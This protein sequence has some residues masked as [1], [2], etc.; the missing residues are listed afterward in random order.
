MSVIVGMMSKIEIEKNVRVVYQ[1]TI[2]KKKWKVKL[3]A[4]K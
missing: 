3:K 4:I 2:K 1:N